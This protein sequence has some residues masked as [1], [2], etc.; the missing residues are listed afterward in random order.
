MTERSPAWRLAL[1]ERE[2]RSEIIPPHG[3]SVLEDISAQLLGK[4]SKKW[5]EKN[6]LTECTIAADTENI[7]MA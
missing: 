3:Q 6:W 5:P 2:V 7:G 4:L 1:E